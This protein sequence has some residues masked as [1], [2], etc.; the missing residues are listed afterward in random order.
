MRQ[1]ESD[2]R[3]IST[4]H[5]IVRRRLVDAGDEIQQRALPEPTAHQRREIAEPHVEIDV[6]QHRNDLTPRW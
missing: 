4:R 5:L 2:R 6:D 3:A 1:S